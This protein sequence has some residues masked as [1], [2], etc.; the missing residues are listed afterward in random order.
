MN[1]ETVQRVNFTDLITKKEH[2]LEILKATLI[3]SLPKEEGEYTDIFDNTWY[4]SG[5]G[6]WYQGTLKDYVATHSS[7][8]DMLAIYNRGPFTKV[9]NHIENVLKEV[10]DSVISLEDAKLSIYG[11]H[12]AIEY[13]RLADRVEKSDSKIPEIKSRYVCKCP[14]NFDHNINLLTLQERSNYV[15]ERIDGQSK[16]QT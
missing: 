13:Y 11:R 12:L 15:G 3:A 14:R 6:H 1:E 8:R 5:Q 4:I 2:E 7:E 9:N 10:N 16:P